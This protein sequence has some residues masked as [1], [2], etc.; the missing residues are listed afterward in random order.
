MHTVL[1]SLSSRSKSNIEVASGFQ[2]CR[3]N[4]LEDVFTHGGPRACFCR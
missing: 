3:R 2:I 1:P 4:N